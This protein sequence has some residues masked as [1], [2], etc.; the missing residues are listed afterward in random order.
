ML[1]TSSFDRTL[2][3]KVDR[4]VSMKIKKFLQN[5]QMFKNLTFRKLYFIYK[6]VYKRP[7]NFRI[8][9]KPEFSMEESKSF[10]N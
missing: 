5:V 6:I 9:P 10:K 3:F 7:L 1:S 4:I 2:H 8:L